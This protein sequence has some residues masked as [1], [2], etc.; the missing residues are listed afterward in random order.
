MAKGKPTGG[1]RVDSSDIDMV[2]LATGTEK[3]RPKK[4]SDL[5]H[6]VQKE[7]IRRQAEAIVDKAN[8]KGKR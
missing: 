5:Q 6:P 8:K 4:S 2:F 3:S 7:R 1:V